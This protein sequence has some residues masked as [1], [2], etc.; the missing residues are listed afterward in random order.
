M[1]MLHG[2]LGSARNLASLAKALS[3]DLD[4]CC[5]DLPNHGQSASDSD[6]RF[7]RMSEAVL[8]VADQNNWSTFS[9][10]GHSLGGK[11][12]MQMAMDS[13]ER[14]CRLLV[15]DIAPVDYPP[16]H[17]EIIEAV[18]TL[19]LNEISSREDALKALESAVP[20]L[21]TRHFLLQSLKR[22]DS[23]F[24]WQMDIENIA[25]NYRHLCKAPSLPTNDRYRSP[26]L[27]VAG[28]RSNY[29]QA[30]HQAA[31]NERFSN[32][33]YRQIAGAGHWIHAEKPARFASVVAGF[34][35]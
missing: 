9:L 20:D 27:F 7:S 33:K 34:F 1:I 12:A 35:E 24:Y 30:E 25:S 4:V 26:V 32:A 6:M 13:P 11:V 8:Q 18:R 2:L 16:F 17:T 23:G 28:E 3:A 15:E 21:A 19:P 14:V 31:I 29:V 22:K 5:I 10:L